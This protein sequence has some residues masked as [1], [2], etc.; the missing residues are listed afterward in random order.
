M[1]KA[2]ILT[3]QHKESKSNNPFFTIRFLQIPHHIDIHMKPIKLQAIPER[4][5]NCLET[6]MQ[7]RN[8][9][10]INYHHNLNIY[11]ELQK[12]LSRLE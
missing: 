6:L 1:L 9:Y 4:K 2:V 10:N 7:I 11:L 12:N 8:R 5:K 3:L